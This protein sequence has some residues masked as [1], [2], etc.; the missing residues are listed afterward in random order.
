SNVL[1][2][3]KLR[4]S[5]AAVWHSTRG[6]FERQLGQIIHLVD[7]LL[8]AS[9][10]TQGKIQLRKSKVNL[11]TILHAAVEAALPAARAA[12][13]VLRVQVPD[14]IM[15]VDGDITRLTQIFSNLLGNAIKFTPAGGEISLRSR[16]EGTE[17]V[18]EVGDTGQGIPDG[19]LER[20]FEMFAQL[21]T[22]ADKAPDGVGMGIGLALVRS[23]TELH[24]GTVQ[25]RSQGLGKGSVF[26]VKLPKSEIALE[27]ALEQAP[28]PQ[29]AP[30]RVLIVD[31]NI[32]AAETL[33]MLLEMMGHTVASAYNGMD[34]L[35][36]MEE[37]KPDCALLDVGLPDIN[38]H[39]L[40][41]RVRVTDWGRP[42]TL[43]AATGWGQQED[44]RKSLEA[45][46]DAHLTKPITLERL[47][48]VLAQHN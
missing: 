47:I 30:R 46:F 31:D 12:G 40:A 39:E 16:E 36:L 5:D 24:G 45:G 32:D 21:N 14:R 2:T 34:G 28:N 1:E 6:V 10:I 48:E 19:Q 35:R 23:L 8:E 29:A 42:M 43:I 22:V 33:A 18:V 44:K 9:R 38:G 17:I 37:F 13:Q 4:P 7:D 20:I 11:V 27:P 15:G 3:L 41:R 25:A 26:E